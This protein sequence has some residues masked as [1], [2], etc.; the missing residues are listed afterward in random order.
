[1]NSQAGR[2]IYLVPKKFGNGKQLI[3]FA[4]R[5]QSD[6]GQSFCAY[7]DNQ[8]WAKD[9]DNT[10]NEVQDYLIEEKGVIFEDDFEDDGLE[11]YED[12]FK[13]QF[14][15]ICLEYGGVCYFDAYLTIFNQTK[16]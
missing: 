9:R 7:V 2:E 6:I 12:W 11:N 3:H 13:D 5:N 15:K 16:Q 1:M 10:F 8:K 14:P 4:Y